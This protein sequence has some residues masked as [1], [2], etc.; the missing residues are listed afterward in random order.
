MRVISE[1]K[2]RQLLTQVDAAGVLGF[3]KVLSNA[4]LKYNKDPSLIPERI[5]VN[6]PELDTVHLFMPTFAQRVGIKTLAGSKEGFKGAVMIIDET[7]GDLKGVLN[8]MTLTAFRTALCSTLPLMKFFQDEVQDQVMTVFGNGLQAYWHVRLTLI[9]F[10]EQFSTVQ[11]AVRSNND[12]SKE[13]S[14]QLSGEFTNVEF[15]LCDEQEV[16]LTSSTVIYGCVPSSQPRILFD[17]LD[18]S[19]KVY[20][21]IIGSYKPHMFE[22]DDKIVQTALQNGKIIVDSYEHTLHEA[23]ELIKNGVTAKNV[24]E[25]GELESVT[26]EQVNNGESLTLVKIVGLAIMDV[27]VGTE[28]LERA[29]KFDIGTT[30]E[31]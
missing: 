19:H 26:K 10:P 29:E 9:L 6:R 24:V 4:L 17:K 16:D 1:E 21:S 11:I 12:K 27:S 25:I 18:L 5:V 13:L 8:A 7:N 14:E 22:V 30:V 15:K 23:G 3:Q 28:I 20:I 31:F 2:I